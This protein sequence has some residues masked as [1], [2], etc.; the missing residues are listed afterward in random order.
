MNKYKLLIRDKQEAKYLIDKGIILKEIWE[1][2]KGKEQEIIFVFLGDKDKFK[3]LKKERFE[4]FQSYL[5]MIHLKE[6][7]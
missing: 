3:E 2:K 7:F 1:N 5:N 4:F 6:L